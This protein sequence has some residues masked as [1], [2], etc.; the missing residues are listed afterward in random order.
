MRYQILPQGVFDLTTRTV[1]L[2]DNSSAAWQEYQAWLT[3]GNTP[4]PPDSVGQDDLPTAKIKRQSEI[5]AY[6]AGLRNKFVRGRSVGE[7]ASWTIKLVEARAWTATQDATQCPTLAAT[8]QIRG[9][10]TAEMAARVLAQ[11]EPFLQAEAAVDGIRGKHCDA[12]EACATVAEII[13]YDWH[14]G[15]PNLTT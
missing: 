1:V 2:P 8:A 13:T 12:V 3:A 7:M 11:A 9:I 6:A 5:D 4:L 14:T 10:S 15:W